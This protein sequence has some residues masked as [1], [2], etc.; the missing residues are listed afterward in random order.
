MRSW[1]SHPRRHGYLVGKAC[2][3]PFVLV[4]KKMF[5]NFLSSI[6]EWITRTGC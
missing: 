1:I 6:E 5:P 2:N 3:C 4:G